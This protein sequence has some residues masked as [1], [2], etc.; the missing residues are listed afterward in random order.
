MVI[1]TC[2]CPRLTFSDPTHYDLLYSKYMYI[3]SALRQIQGGTSL[4][5]VQYIDML[6]YCL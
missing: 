4:L 3:V 2:K 1:I 6:I 5:H